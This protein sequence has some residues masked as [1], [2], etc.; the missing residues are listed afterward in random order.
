MPIMDADI[1]WEQGLVLLACRDRC[2][3][4]FVLNTETVMSELAYETVADVSVKGAPA[5]CALGSFDSEGFAFL[6]TANGQIACWNWRTKALVRL[7]DYCAITEG[8]NLILFDVLPAHGQLFIS[9][10]LG[11]KVISRNPRRFQIHRHQVT[12]TDCILTDTGKIVS[13][14]EQEQTIRWFDAKGLRQVGLRVIT[15]PSAIARTCG[16]DDV[17]VGTGEGLVMRIAPDSEIKPG[18]VFPSLHEG[19]V[20]LF[21]TDNGETIAAGKSGVIVRYRLPL[22]SQ[23]MIRHATGQRM[24]QKVLPGGADSLFLSIH[25]DSERGG[26]TWAITLVELSGREERM[27]STQERFAAV[28]VNTNG[29]VVCVAG[30]TVRILRRRR[31]GWAVTNSRNAPATHA[32]FLYNGAL[33]AVARADVAWIEIWKA[34]ETMETIA[35]I[36]VPA[37]VSCLSAKDDRIVAGLRSGFVIS[38][39]LRTAPFRQDTEITL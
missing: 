38:L 10:H 26:L 4:L 37:E 13:F 31:H 18:E 9:T 28:A 34:D 24:Q 36:E 7:D 27:F 15:A 23:D 30:K 5:K 12:V 35:T 6:A 3:R 2:L 32:T 29:S 20:A 39:Q 8:V 19:V 14:S 33:I 1:D 16:T 11:G 17:L 25:E 22:L 21:E